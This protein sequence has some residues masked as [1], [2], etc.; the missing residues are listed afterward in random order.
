MLLALAFLPLSL[1][2]LPLVTMT[3][4]RLLIMKPLLLMSTTLSRILV[5]SISVSSILVLLV[6]KTSFSYQIVLPPCTR[7]L[8]APGATVE[9]TEDGS[10]IVTAHLP[11]GKRTRL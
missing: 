3:F 9:V 7:V 2:K 8:D 5:V 1:L 4:L 6:V 11:Y 10:T